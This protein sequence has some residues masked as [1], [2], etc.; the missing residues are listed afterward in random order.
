MKVAWNKRNVDYIKRSHKQGKK[1]EKRV[2]EKKNQ[3]KIKGHREIWGIKKE[4]FCEKQWKI[5][6]SVE[7]AESKEEKVSMTN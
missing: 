5:E 7:E 3:E 4:E 2:T 6:T 1:E